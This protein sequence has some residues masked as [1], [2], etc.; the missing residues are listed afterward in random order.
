M[1]HT[2]RTLIFVVVAVV[3]LLVAGLTHF[4]T[5]PSDN[6]DFAEVGKP[7]FEDFQ[8]PGEAT[9]LTVI[10]Y[11]EDTAKAIPFSVEFKDG[12]WRI[13]SHHNYPADG[14]ER[15]AKTA[16]SI[17]GI[18]RG[19]LESRRETDHARYG[20]I[21]PL[22]ETSGTLEGRGQRL[23]MEGKG[24]TKLVDLII[25]KKVKDEGSKA[26]YVR[27]ADEKQTYRTEVDIDLSTKFSDWIEPDLLKL[28]SSDLR[29]LKT[30][31]PIIDAMGRIA[32]EEANKLSRTSS[33]DDWKLD[34]L[35]EE[36]E[37]V[38]KDDVREMVNALGDLKI[39]GV[40]PKP[41]HEGKPLLSA[42]LKF[43]PPKELA[44]NPMILRA[45]LES[46]QIDMQGKGF[47]IG[48]DLED[49]EKQRVYSREGDI[50]A[51]TEKGIVYNLHFGNLFTGSEE[52]IEIGKSNDEKDGTE[53]KSDEDAKSDKPEA[54]KKD[55]DEKD[56]KDPE[57]G[58]D[59]EDTGIKKSRY[60]FVRVE[61]DERFLGDKPVEP[62]KPE[63]PPEVKAAREKEEAK[64]E[65][66]AKEEGEKASDAKAD[67]ASTDAK[68]PDSGEPASDDSGKDADKEGKDE[69]EDK[70]DPKAEYEKALKEY[71]DAKTKYDADLTEYEEKIE[72]GKEEAGVLS[73]RFAD[74]YYA[75]SAESFEKLHLTRADLIKPKEKEEDKDKDDAA[76]ERMPEDAAK[77][78][79]MKDEP[80]T[81]KEEPAAAKKDE[82]AATKKAEPAAKKEQPAATKKAEPAAKKEQPAA[83]KKTEPAAKKETPA[84]KKEPVAAK[85]DEPA[86]KKEQPAA[87]KDKPAADEK[88]D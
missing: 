68:K 29:E 11:N 14:E 16:T 72:K 23:I 48:P 3:S 65:D 47:F 1:N 40:R 7:F 83:T 36:T 35:K 13:P 6:P 63:E 28:S 56:A 86:A 70:P 39:V 43:E 20:V 50:Q 52:E 44:Q 12:L 38:N 4:V 21:D 9:S 78:A 74:W 2:K 41:Q 61:F 57:E 67:E 25:G 49:K 46:L 82:P 26:Y 75:I 71:E 87:K 34:G 54:D 79:V 42:D 80:A 88:K 15:L 8:N 62:V 51:G 19:A 60:L 17:I 85:K 64:D 81:K 84:A 30:A 73:E 24:D 37:E 77:P 27:R 66:P 59:E 33:S 45:V 18:R 53:K 76:A 10:G 22:D 5:K 55:G 69:E 31:R 32:D 58:D